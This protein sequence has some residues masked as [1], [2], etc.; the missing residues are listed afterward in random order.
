M[1]EADVESSCRN[2]GPVSRTA[3]A[4]RVMDQVLR[5]GSIYSTDVNRIVFRSP[6]EPAHLGHIPE[7]SGEG[8]QKGEKLYVSEVRRTKLAHLY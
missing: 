5:Y 2:G 6:L 7:S 1:S 8:G 4:D 3:E